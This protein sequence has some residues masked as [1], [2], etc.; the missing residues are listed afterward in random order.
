MFP[1]EVIQAWREDAVARYPLESCGIISGDRYHPC[2]NIADNPALRFEIDEDVYLSFEQAGI[3]AIVHSHPDGPDCPTRDD[4]ECQMDTNVPWGIINM[5]QGHA[6]EPF[7]WGDQV[8]IAPLIGRTF[9]M[10][11]HDC[12][13]LVRDLFRLEAG[14]TIPDL[15][16]DPSWWEKPGAN[17]LEENFEAMGFE[18]ID[19]I[20]KKFDCFIMPQR[21]TQIECHCGAYIGDGLMLNHFADRISGRQPIGRWIASERIKKF[22]RLKG[23]E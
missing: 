15:P 1:S 6:R 7:F 21:G 10:G 4:M 20:E 16:R 8:P 2:A 5:V 22:F 11:V 17:L 12:Y 3:Q 9:R 19:R 13:A 18:R 14:I 23:K